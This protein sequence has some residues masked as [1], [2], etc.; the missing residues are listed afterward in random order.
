MSH[1]VAVAYLTKAILMEPFKR[2]LEAAWLPNDEFTP[3]W[4]TEPEV[5]E[6]AVWTSL[7]F[8]W[9]LQAIPHHEPPT[10][11]LNGKIRGGS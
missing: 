1:A 3:F 8:K 7:L 9:L 11:S 2:F 10:S 4:F 5:G 6:L